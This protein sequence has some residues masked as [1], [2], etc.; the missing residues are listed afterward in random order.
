MPAIMRIGCNRCDYAQTGSQSITI[1]IKEDGSEVE[2]LHPLERTMAE[3]ATGASW[4]Q[5]VREGRIRYRYALVCLSCGDLGYHGPDQLG[6]GPRR[7]THIGNIVSGVTRKDARKHSCERCGRNTL[8]PL[9]ADETELEILLQFFNW[10]RGRPSRPLC[11]V[12]HTGRLEA[13]MRAIS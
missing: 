4:K 6:E 1:A 2:C 10:L 9:M 11:P 8:Y 5:L 3:E 7:W 13:S 12:C